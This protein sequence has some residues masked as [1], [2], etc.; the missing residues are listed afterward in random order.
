MHTQFI[1]IKPDISSGPER[2]TPVPGLRMLCG[3][4]AV[5]SSS[6]L[7]MVFAANHAIIHRV[8]R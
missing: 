3:R 1:I 2:A 4:E 6:R 7:G 8:L 5:L